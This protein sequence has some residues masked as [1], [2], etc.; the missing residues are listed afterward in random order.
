M[1]HGDGKRE[2]KREKE[3]E[4]ER[5][6]KERKSRRTYNVER[7]VKPVKVPGA[8]LAILLLDKPLCFMHKL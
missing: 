6:R 1:H 5:E 7:A 2:R 4:R 3:K 8:I